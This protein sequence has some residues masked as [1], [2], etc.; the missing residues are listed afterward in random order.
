MARFSRDRVKTIRIACEGDDEVEFLRFLISR[1]HVR[2]SGFT[3][4]LKPLHGRGLKTMLA[5]VRGDFVKYNDTYLFVDRHTI[6]TATK[7]SPPRSIGLL[8]SNPCL[9]A[10]ICHILGSNEAFENTSE[11]DCKKHLRDVYGCD[12][13]TEKWLKG[14]ITD[15]M[16][17]KGVKTI[18]CLNKIERILKEGKIMITVT[19]KKGSTSND[20]YSRTCGRISCVYGVREGL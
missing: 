15:K 19:A 1:W 5:E 14:H 11:K 3:I 12:A 10:L 7:I 9:E 16:L 17:E 20:S 4:A 2:K 13:I 18:Q 8:V 6:D